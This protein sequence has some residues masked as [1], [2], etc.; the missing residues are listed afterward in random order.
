MSFAENVLA[1]ARALLVNYHNFDSMQTHFKLLLDAVLDEMK[2]EGVTRFNDPELP[3]RIR[4]GFLTGFL[5]RLERLYDIFLANQ[6]KH[7]DDREVF[8]ARIKPIFDE[9]L[10]MREE[11]FTNMIIN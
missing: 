9:Y 4:E 5:A 3:I 1:N 7:G 2:Y 6:P 11:F 10:Q 8:V